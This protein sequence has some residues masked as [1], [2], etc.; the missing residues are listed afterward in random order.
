MRLMVSGWLGGGGFGTWFLFSWT[1]R[2]P[3]SAENCRAN[4]CYRDCLFPF[5][6]AL[7]KAVPV[8]AFAKRPGSINCADTGWAHWGNGDWAQAS[9]PCIGAQM[10]PGVGCRTVMY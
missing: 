2:Q 9:C 8:R 6:A 3:R 10:G 5:L 4:E 1:A 7:G